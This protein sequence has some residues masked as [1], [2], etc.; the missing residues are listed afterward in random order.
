MD[1]IL[2]KYS[3]FF[4]D[5]GGFQKAI[6]DFKKLGDEFIKEADRIRKGAD[7]ADIA[8]IRAVSDLED[9]IQSLTKTQKA[10]ADTLEEVEEL[11]EDLNE[12]E[13]KGLK[14][15]EEQDKA[16]AKLN[17]TLAQQK[18]ALKIINEA[19]KQGEISI[20]KAAEARGRLQ[21]ETKAT[22]VE[23]SKYTKEV[24][25][26]NKLSVRQQKL[27]KAQETLRTNQARSLQEIRERLAALRLVASEI[28]ITTPEGVAEVAALNDEINSL[29]DTL[30]E[31]SDKFIQNKINVGNYEESIQ[32]ALAGTEGFATGIG[33]LDK[34]LNNVVQAL[35]LNSKQLADLEEG[36]E[37][38]A[39]GA[40][41]LIVQF[42]R[43]NKVLK[44]SIIGVVVL[45]IA[46]LG[47]AFGNT[48]AGSIRLEK[49]L[50]TLQAALTGFGQIARE[51]F[52]AI[53]E[54]A[55]ISFDSI[56]TLFTKGPAAVFENFGNNL[57][58]IEQAFVDLGKTIDN[59]GTGI[60]AGLDNIEN[61]FNIET[62][63]RELNRELAEL[64]GRLQLAQIASADSTRSLRQQ[65]DA[66]RE[67]LRLQDEIAK[68]RVEIARQSLEEVNE[69]VK[70]NIEL[71]AQEVANIDLA[72]KGAAFAVATAE[73]TKQRGVDL[74]INKDLIVEQAEALVAL[75]EAENEQ[76]ANSAENAKERREIQ[77]D[78][79]EQNLDLLIDFIDTE[80]NLNEQAITNTRERFADRVIEF[81]RF[82]KKFREN[83]QRELNEFNKFA[84][85]IGADLDLEIEFDEE[86]NFQ[87]LNEGIALSTDNI[88]D[89]NEELQSLGLPEI[90]INRFRE[91]IIEARNGQRDFKTLNIE[92]AETGRLVNELSE[93][94]LVDQAELDALDALNE[95]IN[96]LGEIDPAG[97]SSEGRTALL[98][99]LEDLEEERTAI[100]KRAEDQR[101]G[102]R[103]LA[104]D[105]ELRG[106]KEGSDR[107]IELEREKAAIIKGL[108]DQELAD[109]KAAK[110]EEI[111]AAEDAA[112]K[113]EALQK[114]IRDATFAALN[115][116]LDK[117]VESNQERVSA[118]EKRITDVEEREDQQRTRAENGLANTLAF[119]QRERAKAE[120]ELQK[121]Q[122]RLQ[123]AEQARALFTAYTAN[124]QNAELAKIPGGALAAT[125]KDFAI[126]QALA[127][128]FGEG[129]IIEDVL[130]TTDGK[131]IIRGRSHSGKGG[132]IPVLV[133]GQEGIFSKKEMANLG[134]GNFYDIK[135]AAG[136]G[137]IDRN[138]FTGQK[139]EFLA[140]GTVIQKTDTRI[141]SELREVKKAIK[142]KPTQIISVPEIVDGVLT[143]TETVTARRTT[144]RNHYQI[145]KPRL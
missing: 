136:L 115:Q 90:V 18:T 45:G 99:Q 39:G 57:D 3:D 138:F 4:E 95:R 46:A 75:T 94:L 133:E 23:L 34:A 61:A 58:R 38:G 142:E 16:I 71:N 21:L 52:S 97:L 127:A 15:T 141:I 107:A 92:L 65:L 104:I 124:A 67:S 145:K 53:G 130:K 114:K 105:E 81:E 110:E 14:L 47:S 42:G 50:T 126:L 111:K 25:N 60:V 135:S 11:T 62:N 28:D 103:L 118:A 116:I 128:S 29:T 80:K 30:E 143:F 13:E 20:T 22:R 96:A 74:E 43:L 82:V 44:A 93:N 37:N 129:G 19:E 32:N 2:I 7:L 33:V 10:Y 121:Q 102:N 98:K 17:V 9:Q 84:Q 85:Q 64:E 131:G 83:A 140:G 63:I 88:V 24:L 54:A 31:N 55:S 12:T 35:T 139:E 36:L 125:L 68:R 119:E 27:L 48:V 132:G 100:S 134:K 77:R 117:V 87:V 108:I 8:N 51:I 26:D 109:K 1:N 120:L 59:V 89:L 73:L 101:K 66:N 5:D 6:D 137:P 78:L 72:Q 56:T 113:Q 70:A 76:A 40:K 91:F 112:K 41:R 144:K 106:L 49:A 123:R 79:F 86:G 69:R 122:K